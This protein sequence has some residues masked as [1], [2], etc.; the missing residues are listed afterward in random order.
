MDYHADQVPIVQQAN[1]VWCVYPI[2]GCYT[3]LQ[4]HLFWVVCA[5]VLF[6]HAHEWLTRA[7][8]GFAASY[9]AAAAAHQV[10]LAFQAGPQHDADIFATDQVTQTSMLMLVAVAL[11]CPGLVRRTPL[12]MVMGWVG[13]VFAAHLAGALVSARLWDG[14]SRSLVLSACRGDG[15]CDDPCGRMQASTFFRGYGGDAMVPLRWDTVNVTYAAPSL[16]P[17]P[18]LDDTV[19]VM[20][21]KGPGWEVVRFMVKQALKVALPMAV[22]KVNAVHSPQEVR[23]KVFLR[24][25]SRRQLRPHL[26]RAGWKAWTLWTF[27]W[28]RQA[29]WLLCTLVPAFAMIDLPFRVVCFFLFHAFGFRIP[30]VDDVTYLEPCI[31]WPRY[32]AGRLPHLVPR[33]PAAD[34]TGGDLPA[35]AARVRVRPRGRA[36]VALAGRHAGA[37]G[38]HPGAHD[39]GAVASA[40]AAGRRRRRRAGPHGLAGRGLRPARVRGRGLAGGARA[41]GGEGVVAP[42]RGRAGGVDAGEP[43]ARRVGGD[44]AADDALG[45]GAGRRAQEGPGG[46]PAADEGPGPAELGRRGAGAAQRGAE[47]G[48]LGE[49]DG[50]RGW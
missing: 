30:E 26:L 41:R 40:A 10:L 18:S 4:R 27:V 6:G 7:A 15:P 32:Q 17:A 20:P 11:F 47:G 29:C 2:S 39:R 25:L 28:A 21:E 43:R 34:H 33:A 5:F 22:A 3:S 37:G 49:D 16:P 44:V 24:S 13:L 19:V 38:R 1:R 42:A 46:D 9:S 12:V 35:D 48:E 8:I 36:V 31:T 14:V 23:D 45:A 50:C